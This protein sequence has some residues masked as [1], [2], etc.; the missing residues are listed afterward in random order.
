[1]G[2]VQRSIVVGCPPEQVFAVLA[3]IEQLPSFSSMTVD[4]RGG[5]GRALRTGDRFTQVIRLVGK[6]LE[7][8]WQVVEV[9]EP[10]LLRLSGDAPG[11]ATATLVERLTPEGTGTRVELDVEYDLPLGLLGDAIDA[12]FLERKNTEQAEEILATLKRRCE[13]GH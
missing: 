12:I 7:S 6:E 2:H 11:G 9:H 1:M 13:A 8:D 3:D 10:T 4:V 5:P